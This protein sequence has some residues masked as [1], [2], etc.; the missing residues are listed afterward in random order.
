MKAKPTQKQLDFMS[1][2]WGVF[3]HFGIRT[4]YEGHSDWDEQEMLATAFAPTQLDCRQWIRTIKEAGASY[5][6]L[7]AKHHDGFA[8]WPTKYS[9]FSVACSPWKDGKGD[10]VHEYVEACRE[11]GLHVGLY[12]S[13]AEYHMANMN[14]TQYD[15]Y[16]INQV[17]ELLTQ[18]GMVDYLWFD[19]NGSQ[20]HTYDARRIIG[21]VR[22]MQPGI[23]LFGMWDPDVR[24]VGNEA[25]YASETN[26][27]TESAIDFSH[28]GDRQNWFNVPQFIPA[29]C[30][31]M[32]RLHNWFY[33]DKDEDTVKELDELMGLYYG[34]IGRG[35]NLLINI[36]PNRDGLMPPRDTEHL[37]AMGA[38]I[39]RRFSTS[40]A[41]VIAPSQQGGQFVLDLPR[42]TLVNHVVIEEDLLDGEAVKEFLVKVAS[43]PTETVFEIFT[44]KSIGHKK[45]CQFPTVNTNRIILEVT[46]AF[47]GVKLTKVAVFYVEPHQ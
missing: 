28:I 34:S 41:E 43:Y 35:A 9:D 23:R 19:G 11:F 12:Y 44:G 26:Y 37:L 31:C 20:K 18:Y 2:E 10:V 27:N 38:E 30:D 46:D 6:I 25:G 36:G 3:I 1:W 5:A 40:I 24:W 7:T 15:D 17:S 29:E 22:Q 32:M 33:S 21:A 39:R 13:P 45:I 16:F 8:N 14:G 42:L 47:G 4:F